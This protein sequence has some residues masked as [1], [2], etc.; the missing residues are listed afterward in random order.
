MSENKKT[1]LEKA[2]LEAREIENAAIKSATKIVEESVISKIEE[3]VRETLKGLELNESVSIEVGDADFDISV[4]DGKTSITVDAEEED[5]VVT[6][7]DSEEEE[8]E[9]K[10]SEE[11]EE[12]EET[13][14]LENLEDEESEEEDIF[15]VNGLFEEEAPAELE[16][17]TPTEEPAEAPNEELA[18]PDDALKNTP[19]EVANPFADILA[20]LDDISSKLDSAENNAVEAN[21]Q[22]EEVATEETVEAPEAEGEVEIVDDEADVVA[23]NDSLE[24]IN[25]DEIISEMMDEME[26]VNEG[27]ELHLDDDNDGNFNITSI[28]LENGQTISLSNEDE[29]NDGDLDLGNDDEEFEFDSEEDDNDDEELD[30]D[31]D[32]EEEDEDVLDS[33]DEEMEE[34]DELDET[35]GLGSGVQRA[36]GNDKNKDGHHA[37]LNEDK[38]QYEAKLAELNK[39]NASLKESLKEYKES[40]KVLR[41][42]I[43]EVQTFNAKLAYVN[44]LFSKGGLTNDEKVQIAENFDSVNTIEEA[45]TLY[46]KFINESKNLSESKTEQ[47]KSKLKSNN[48]VVVN[49]T[50]SEAL[51]ESKE[52]SRM[53]QL[54]G[55]KTLND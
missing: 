11:S 22:G 39:E 19:T 32:S 23:E 6:P 16:T 20:K 25:I 4:N 12:S 34:E 33:N 38:T 44:K 14:D 45:K 15:E 54:A 7:I 21:E 10:E 51:Y 17:E 26:I 49:S 40:F 8:M 18:L 52:V 36:F 1:S 24:E 55:I 35:R 43:N 31:L 28:E 27:M 50:K 30:L 48:P 37:P 41:K 42:Q 9:T 2:L 13:E 29:D 53:R 46:N 3:T 47:L 5:V